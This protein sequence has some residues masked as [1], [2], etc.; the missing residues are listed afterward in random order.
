MKLVSEV[1]ED[2]RPLELELQLM[3][4]SVTATP[5]IL[6]SEVLSLSL[7]L[8]KSEVGSTKS[9]VWSF[10]VCCLVFGIWNLELGT[11]YLRLLLNLTLELALDKDIK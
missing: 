5:I 11:C 8:R 1:T 6:L 10:V 9:G 2:A 4:Y 7:H 3:S